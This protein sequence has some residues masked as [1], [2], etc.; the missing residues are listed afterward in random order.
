MHICSFFLLVVVLVLTSMS[1][2]SSATEP[3]EWKLIEAVKR[4]DDVTNERIIWGSRASPESH[5]ECHFYLVN[6]R[7]H[8]MEQLLNE[9]SD[10]RNPKYG[11]HLTHE[12]VQAMSHNEEGERLLREYLASINATVTKSANNAVH[13]TAPIS[14]WEGALKTE[15]FE[16]RLNE[17]DATPVLRCRHYS[18]PTTVAAHITTVM[19]TIQLPFK[20]HRGGPKKMPIHRKLDLK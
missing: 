15:F 8:E 6:P 2:I 18:L 19:N 12:Q 17:E 10:P 13:A 4:D 16:V 11:K 1:E 7:Q 9:V 5:H 20:I 14:V 3:N